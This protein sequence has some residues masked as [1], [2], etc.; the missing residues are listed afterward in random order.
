MPKNFREASR[1][2]LP[3]NIDSARI[4]LQGLDFLLHDEEQWPEQPD[5]LAQRKDARFLIT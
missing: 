1:G 3:D 4:W 2:L 5:F